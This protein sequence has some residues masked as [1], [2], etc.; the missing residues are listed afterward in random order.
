MM[1]ENRVLRILF[2]PKKEELARGLRRLHN[3]E[4]HKLYASPSFIR[5]NK[6]RRMGWAGHV[7]RMGEVRNAYNIFVRELEWKR[8][9]KS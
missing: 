1:S 2:G 4:L 8:T 3:E 7:E 9:W 5:V 6:S